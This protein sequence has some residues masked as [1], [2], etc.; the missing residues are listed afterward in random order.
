MTTPFCFAEAVAPVVEEID[1][2]VAGEHRRSGG[3]GGGSGARPPEEAG[4]QGDEERQGENAR[5]RLRRCI[6]GVRPSWWARSP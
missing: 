3:T 2:H 1:D 4:G 6:I 5:M